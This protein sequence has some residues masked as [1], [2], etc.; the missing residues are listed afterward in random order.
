MKKGLIFGGAAIALGTVAY[1][2]FGKD[3]KN[4][5]EN[6]PE[7][8]T[9]PVKEISN[10]QI[11]EERED[12]FDILSKNDPLEDFSHRRAL[13]VM[14]RI[15]KCDAETEE[16]RETLNDFMSY[17]QLLNYSWDEILTEVNKIPVYDEDAGRRDLRLFIL[18]GRSRDAFYSDSVNSS[19]DTEELEETFE[20]IKCLDNLIEKW[21]L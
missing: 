13:Y 1:F 17:F 11:K 12:Y 16:G 20:W 21:G 4:T 14:A 15:Q 9:F 6:T 10:I 8:Q 7:K 19:L 2:L 18:L 5:S 3:K